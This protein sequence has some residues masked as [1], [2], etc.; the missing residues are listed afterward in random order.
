MQG[1]GRIFA[2]KNQKK[3]QTGGGGGGGG[4]AKDARMK[5]QESLVRFGKPKFIQRSEGVKIEVGGQK[6]KVE[7]DFK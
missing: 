4:G 2:V 6:K 7:H 3:N 1:R 5:R